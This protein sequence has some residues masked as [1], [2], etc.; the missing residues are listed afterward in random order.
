MPGPRSSRHRWS[1]PTRG[2]IAWANSGGRQIR[3]VEPLP[4][5]GPRSG[6][7]R[8]AGGAPP[9]RCGRYKRRE[10]RR[11][12]HARGP[13]RP[14]RLRGC[15]RDKPREG[16]ARCGRGRPHRAPAVGRPGP[17]RGRERSSR[18]AAGP[19]PAA[20]RPISRSPALPP[21]GRPGSDGPGRAIVESPEFCGQLRGQPALPARVAS[22]PV[23]EQEVEDAERAFVGGGNGCIDVGSKRPRAVREG[24]GDSRRTNV[25]RATAHRSSVGSRGRRKHLRWGIAMNERSRRWR[26]STSAMLNPHVN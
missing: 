19:A 17:I 23:G 2:A 12:R 25:R 10:P 11:R 7:H 24:H 14:S 1:P 18:G 8:R 26:R 3:L 20:D 6:G 22:K 5:C 15:C 4:R 21:S 13:R 16:V 9:A